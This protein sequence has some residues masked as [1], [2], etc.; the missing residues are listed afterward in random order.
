MNKEKFITNKEFKI[1]RNLFEYDILMTIHKLDKRI[2]KLE[3]DRINDS[4]WDVNVK[5][6]T[7][8]CMLRKGVYKLTQEERVKK[9]NEGIETAKKINDALREINKL[10]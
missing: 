4:M 10:L 3:T 5:L 9:F 6:F 7:A 8:F 1:Y 2:E